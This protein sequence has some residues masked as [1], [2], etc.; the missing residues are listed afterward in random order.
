VRSNG[1]VGN[2]EYLEV[3]PDSTPNRVKLRKLT[4]LL[5]FRPVM[6]DGVP[7]RAENVLLT[8]RMPAAR[9]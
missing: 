9:K 5:Q 2:V 6:R 3:T 7:V 8:V 1:Q 4:E